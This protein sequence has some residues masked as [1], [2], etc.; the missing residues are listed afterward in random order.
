MFP[1]WTAEQL[2]QV[3]DGGIE[4]I[5]EP[6]SP[7]AV[8][9]AQRPIPVTTP[10]G[11]GVADV[12]AVFATRSEFTHQIPPR[13]VFDG[14]QRIRMVGLSLNL[15]CQH[16]PDKALLNL[17]ESGTSV[18]CLFLDPA[19]QYIKVRE[20]EESH[21]PGLLA[22]LTTVNIAALRRI[23]TRLSL[24][25]RENLKIRTYD[26]TVRFNITLIDDKMCVV[27]PYLPDARGVESP[28]LVIQKQPT[29]VGLF[30]TFTQVFASMWDRAKE[31][32]E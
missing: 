17:L 6:P 22:T 10:C 20:Q 18:E 8:K 31:I 30:D 27:Q 5:P 26:E 7:P 12:I 19:G 24:E 16:Y 9:S 32:S 3:H 13:Q 1:G 23:R 14:A 28:T 11:H 15:L 2:F 4:F 29:V 25:G 21:P